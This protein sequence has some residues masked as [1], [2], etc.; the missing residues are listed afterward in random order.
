[1][2]AHKTCDNITYTILFIYLFFA[3]I[4]TTNYYSLSRLLSLF[5]SVLL[6]NA[7]KFSLGILNKKDLLSHRR[8]RTERRLIHPASTWAVK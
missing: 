6:A 7:T 3:K 8:A 2:I 1:M 4:T 5:L